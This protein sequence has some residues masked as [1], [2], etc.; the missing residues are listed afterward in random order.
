MTENVAENYNGQQGDIWDA[1]KDMTI[2]MLG[3]TISLFVIGI[4]Q[5]RS[6]K[7]NR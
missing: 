3:S 1:H 2:A 5:Q 6:M 7:T 4:S